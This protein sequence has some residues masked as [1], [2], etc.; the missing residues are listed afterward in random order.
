VKRLLLISNS[1]SFGGGY[2]EHCEAELR[3]FLHGV[4]RVLFVPYALADH[5]G[6]AGKARE[7][8]DELGFRL[9]SIHE[10]DD[11]VAAVG[12]AEAIFIGGG[13]TFRLLNG[14]YGQGLIEPIRSRVEQGIPYVGTSAGS[15]VACLTIKTT[16]DMPIVQPP[17]FDALALV[18]FNLNPHYLDPDPGSTHMGETRELRITEFHEENTP[19]VV[20]LRESA[21]LRIEGDAVTLKG[22]TGARVFRRGQPPEELAP[23]ASMEFLLG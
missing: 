5:D 22:T 10:A 18:P 7:R 11:P 3:E 6:Y 12:S 14:L 20:G 19:V 17:S 8:F 2:L 21:M 1:T 16:N 4:G 23:G 13:N 15:N 9:D